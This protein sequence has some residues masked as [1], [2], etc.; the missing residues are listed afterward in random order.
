MVRT[1]Q[2]FATANPGFDPHNLLTMQ[3]ALPPSNYAAAPQISAFYYR[4]LRGL[5]GM[6]GVRS[7]AARAI[8]GDADGMSIEGNAVPRAGEVRPS[9]YSVTGQYFETLFLPI[10]EGRAI[11]DSDDE[12]YPLAVVVSESV[13]RHYWPGR[14]P[15]GAHV[16]ISNGDRR[17]LTI[18]GVCGDTK[19]WFSNQP[20]PRV[21]V[22]FRQA[23]HRDARIL[24]RTVGEP[25]PALTG[26]IAEIHQVDRSQPAFAIKTIE[27]EIAEE[28]SGVRAAAV[29]MTTYSL[30]ALLLAVTGIY[31]VIAYSMEQRTH[32][33]GIRM[34]LGARPEDIL[35]M[36][37]ADSLRLGGLGLVIG[38]LSAAVRKL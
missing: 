7:A 21:Y 4:V 12:G 26:A 2:A 25:L 9:V 1:F 13:A 33:I 24:V 34:A 35:R 22:S 23:P 27:Q 17:W 3:L 29:S 6:P 19:D 18:V 38:E 30:I 28:T 32:E 36:A 37:L 15:L 5:G 11:R 16:R 20:V 31:A 10:L 8:A 14:T